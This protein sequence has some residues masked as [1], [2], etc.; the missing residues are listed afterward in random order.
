MTDIYAI[1]H[2]ISHACQHIK[3]NQSYSSG[4]T[5]AKILEISR[6]WWHKD[7]AVFVIC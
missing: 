5:V 3:V 2:F 6:E 1:I 7:G 4:D